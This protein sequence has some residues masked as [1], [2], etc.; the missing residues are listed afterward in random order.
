MCVKCGNTQGPCGLGLSS[1]VSCGEGREQGLSQQEEQ[2]VQTRVW[3]GH[4]TAGGERA[5]NSDVFLSHPPLP[6]LMMKEIQWCLNIG[7]SQIMK[8]PVRSSYK[9][10]SSK[11]RGGTEDMCV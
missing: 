10:F 7:R 3:T 6:Q 9:Q 11:P 5:G 8:G 4:L 2:G 1:V